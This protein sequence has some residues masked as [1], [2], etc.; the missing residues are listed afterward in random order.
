MQVGGG[1][2]RRHGGL[3]S[4]GEQRGARR[5]TLDPGFDRRHAE[6][7]LAHVAEAEADPAADPAAV[8]IVDEMAAL[9]LDIFAKEK[10][11]SKIIPN[12]VGF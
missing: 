2:D 6:D 5:L 7:R 12:L 10:G 1:V 11:L 9:P 4:G 8:P 3:R